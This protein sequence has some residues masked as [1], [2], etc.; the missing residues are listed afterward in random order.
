MAQCPKPYLSSASLQIAG[1]GKSL[2]AAAPGKKAVSAF[3]LPLSQLLTLNALWDPRPS[4]W[5]ALCPLSQLPPPQPQR[6]QTTPHLRLFSALVGVSLG[7]GSS[8]PPAP[9]APHPTKGVGDGHTSAP[10][11]PAKLHPLPPVYSAPSLTLPLG[12]Q[13][14]RKGG[15]EWG[16]G[17]PRALQTETDRVGSR[18]SLK[19]PLLPLLPSPVEGRGCQ[20]RASRALGNSP[21]PPPLPLPGGEA[22]PRTGA[23]SPPPPPSGSCCSL[24]LRSGSTSFLRRE[25]ARV[26][27]CW[28]VRGRR[29]E[30]TWPSGLGL[31]E[32]E[33]ELGR[34]GWGRREPTAEAEVLT[35]LPHP[36]VP[37]R[38]PHPLL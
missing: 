16:G 8:P 14:S 24:R 1:Q 37:R 9:S 23:P 36:R 10:G 20:G 34:M 7:S 6:L 27:C 33:Q 26:V 12:L 2:R 3:S 11:S 38:Q 19:P 18:D 13:G 31:R 28:G 25:K 5:G 21:R 35:S 30:I 29:F 4:P 17:G 22:P 15:C 32:Q